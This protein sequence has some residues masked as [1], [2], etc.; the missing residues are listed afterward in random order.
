MKSPGVLA[1][2][3]PFLRNHKTQSLAAH[4]GYALEGGFDEYER[5]YSNDRR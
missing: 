5:H 3:A 4:V 2:G 1:P